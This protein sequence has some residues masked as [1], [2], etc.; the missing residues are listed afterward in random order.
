VT[1]NI[2][3]NF[4]GEKPTPATPTAT[5]NVVKKPVKYL[6]EPDIRPVQFPKIELVKNL[7]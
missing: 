2:A 1:Q 3:Q 4:L 7:D 6:G 5:T